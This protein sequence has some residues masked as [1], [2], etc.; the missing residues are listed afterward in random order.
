MPMIEI[1]QSTFERLQR[2]STP[3]VDTASSVINRLLDAYEGTATR[4]SV[5]PPLPSTNIKE[6]GTD[7]PPDLTHTKIL[8]ADFCRQ[9]LEISEANWNGL[10]NAA[11]RK[12][13]QK[14]TDYDELRKLI[15]VNFVLGPK[16]DDGYRYL[17]DVGLSVQGQDANAAFRA[18]LHIARR[19]GCSLNVIFVWRM[20]PKAAFPGVTGQMHLSG[21][22]NISGDFTN[23][24]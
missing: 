4:G 1:D 18:V 12:V 20:T 14:T 5:V 10:L 9:R 13:R 8:T 15:T 21:D 7:L 6:F 17:E 2:L 24:N 23:T 11:I 16:K 22:H 3:L 19:L